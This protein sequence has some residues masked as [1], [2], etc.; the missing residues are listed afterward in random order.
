MGCNLVAGGG[1]WREGARTE[2]RG[3]TLEEAGGRKVVGDNCAEVST[4]EGSR[5]QMESRLADHSSASRTGRG[6]RAW[7]AIR[8]Y[9]PCCCQA[10]HKVCIRLSTTLRYARTQDC[11]RPE[12]I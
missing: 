8:L 4:S 12:L 3:E 2:E 7:E 6:A 11:S 5:A 10:V 1:V 9:G